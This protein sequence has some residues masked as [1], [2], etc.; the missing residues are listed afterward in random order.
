MKQRDEVGEA[1][2]HVRE[3]AGDDPVALEH[4]ALMLAAEVARL[5]P[6]AQAAQ[7]Y[8]MAGLCGNVDIRVD[9][10]RLVEVARTDR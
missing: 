3:Y 9:W 5:R 4:W 7:A 8:V 10:A 2:V 6:I 1:I